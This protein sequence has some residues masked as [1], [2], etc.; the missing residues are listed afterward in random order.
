MLLGLDHKVLVVHIVH[1]NRLQKNKMPRS[2]RPELRRHIPNIKCEDCKEEL[3]YM[4]ELNEIMIC[5]RCFTMYDF[6]KFK[7]KDKS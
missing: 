6:K 7:E 3:E 1:K 4:C 2:K 5:P